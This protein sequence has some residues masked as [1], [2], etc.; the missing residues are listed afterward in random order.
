MPLFA[1]SLALEEASLAVAVGGTG[2]GI[3]FG[4]SG[5]VLFDKATVELVG[6]VSEEVAERLLDARGCRTAIVNEDAGVGVCVEDPVLE[7]VEQILIQLETGVARG[8]RG[9][10]DIGVLGLLVPCSLVDRL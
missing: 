10:V 3:G 5:D 2:V 9:D 4:P 8:E 1:H 6:E 7:R